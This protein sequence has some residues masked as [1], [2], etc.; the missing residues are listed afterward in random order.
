MRRG[1]Y[2]LP[3]APQ[4]SPARD[5]IER[6]TNFVND[7]LN[8]PR[9]LSVAWELLRGDVVDLAVMKATLTQFD[10]VFGLRLVEWA[11]REE[12]VPD[13]IKALADARAAARKAKDWFE[14]DRLRDALHAAGWEMEDRPDGYSLKRKT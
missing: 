9:A 1:Y 5:Y 4:A 14:A 10:R 11:P 13:E 3:A 8:L 6:F 12:F 7:D 2:A